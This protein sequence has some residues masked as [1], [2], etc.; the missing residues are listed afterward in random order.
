MNEHLSIKHFSPGIWI[1]AEVKRKIEPGVL[2]LNVS[3][4]FTSTISILDLD[5]NLS[6]AEI[7]FRSIKEGDRIQA[8]VFEVSPELNYIRFS[9]KHLIEKPF[10]TREWRE[11]TLGSTVSGKSVDQLLNGIIIEL[12]N[13]LTGILFDTS[14]TGEEFLVVKKDKYTNLLTLSK[15]EEKVIPENLKTK[16]FRESIINPKDEDFKSFD[17]FKKSIYIDFA[18]PNELEYLESAFQKEPNLFSK[19]FVSPFKLY[20]SFGMNHSA[21]EN[22]QSQVVPS[23]LKKAN[24]DEAIT[25][26]AIEIIKNQLFWIGLSKRKDN[27]SDYFTVYNENLSFHGIVNQLD[28]ESCQFFVF[29][30]SFGRKNFNASKG[31]QLSSKYGSFVLTEGISI[32]TPTDNIP[33]GETKEQVGIYNRLTIKNEALKISNSL[34]SKTGEIIRSEG[35]SLQIFDKFLEYQI[36]LAKKSLPTPFPLKEIKR[37]HGGDRISWVL[38]AEVED[39]FGKD[40]EGDVFLDLKELV[41]STKQD[42]EFDYKKIGSAKARQLGESWILLIEDS[43]PLNEVKNLFIQKKA[44]LRQFQVQREI[45]R[46]FFDKKLKLDHV[47]NLLVDQ[48]R[49][50]APNISQVKLTNKDL[51]K[52]EREQ[53]ENNQVKAVRKAIGN[54]GL[55]LIQ[56]PP[57][58]GKTTVISE[59]VKQLVNAGEKVLVTSQTH[60]AV[61]NVLEKLAKEKT[62]S[63][64]RIGSINKIRQSLQSYH[65]SEQINAYTSD[66]LKF[67]DVQKAI[68]ELSREG[69][70][71]EELK[72]IVRVLRDDYSEVI[73]DKLSGFNFNLIALLDSGD[74]KNKDSILRTLNKWRSNMKLGLGVIIEPILYNSVDVVFATCL[75]IKLDREFSQIQFKFDT[76]IIDEAGKANLA[77]SLVAISMAKKIILVGD[78][79]QLPPYIESDLLD[80]SEEGSFPRSKYGFRFNKD[81]IEYALKTSF[82]EFLIRRIQNNQFPKSNK[83]ML[84][85]QHRMHPNIGKFVSESFYDGEVNMGASTHRNRLELP[86]P[87]EKEIIFIS[88]GAFNN[89]YEQRNGFSIIN[90]TEAIIIIQDVLPKLIEF[91]VKGKDVGI[92]A[93]YKSQVSLIKKE[94]EL[95]GNE[96]LAEIEVATLDSFQ[97]MEFD[98][99]IF[100]FTRSASPDQENKRVGFLDDARRLNVAFSRAKKKLILI[101]NSRTLTHK[102]S[103]YDGLFSFTKLFQKL[104]ELSNDESIG[105]FYELN[106]NDYDFK[107]RFERFKEEHPIGS[108]TTGTIKAIMPYGLF[109]TINGTDGLVYKNNISQ[110][111]I[112][113]ISDIFII[114]QEVKVMILDL[115]DHEKRVALGIKQVNEIFD[116]ENSSLP[117]GSNYLTYKQFKKKNPIGSIIIGKIKRIES[118][119]VLLSVNGLTG[120]LHISNIS[121]NRNESLTE[122][123]SLDKQLK[124]LVHAYDDKKENIQFG[125]KQLK[126]EENWIKFK[127]E[128]PVKSVLQVKI[129]QITGIGLLVKSTSGFSG[130]IHKSQLN[131]NRRRALKSHYAKGEYLS[132]M[133]MSYND[134]KKMIELSET[135]TILMN[136]STNV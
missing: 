20:L 108:I 61:D 119:G 122:M 6:R 134:K 2:E 16:E 48:K 109:V 120:L 7:K 29:S 131:P 78:Q 117:I 124:V 63:L 19:E 22:F 103:H 62:L 28:D 49:I 132:A 4:N 85:Y 14:Y 129:L 30:V 24:T 80:A 41:K 130:L 84:N 114:G 36:D 64:L 50:L 83:E 47:E 107:S 17:N 90:Q 116:S 102:S 46:D 76:V 38:P 100:S 79:K 115:D 54:K 25:K 74:I 40:E 87:F 58:T 39:Y 127:T 101:G 55:F 1:E 37:T 86:A 59:V 52:T 96:S 53:P 5:W 113:N 104:E 45:I 99:I 95:T 51:I 125:L 70:S 69:K 60:I 97:G 27:D 67:I 91:G 81:E 32:L 43:L 110:Y 126:L 128:N 8:A 9:T 136:R 77:E 42:K 26:E 118:Y 133:I 94:I 123:F 15:R 31:K 121:N 65:P 93:P 98:I 13:G 12:K 89:P 56:G 10:E 66:F 111:S 44:S 71:E 11:L 112:N 21:W 92:I 88:T 73:R 3:K 75:G 105:G 68:I 135:M 18:E 106:D 34:K 82:F 35:K 72:A 57:G 23:I 33:I